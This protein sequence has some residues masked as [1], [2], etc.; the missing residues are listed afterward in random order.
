MFRTMLMLVLAAAAGY[1]GWIAYGLYNEPKQQLADKQAELEKVS[2]DLTARR[3]EIVELTTHLE[4]K[5]REIDR[6]EVA[7]QLLK[8]RH[9][10]ARLKVLDQQEVEVPA[11]EAGAAPTKK[12][13]TK[14]E[15]VE[16]N[17]E[18]QP[19]GKPREFEIDGD[20]VFIDYLRV[21]FDDKYVE[22]SDLD[23][24][25]AICLFQRV[26]GE[27]QQPIDGFQLDD[28]GARPTAYARGS[29]MSDFERKIWS[30]FWTIANDPQQAAEMGIHAAH[31]VASAMRVKPGKTYEVD[32]RSTGDM[33]IRPVDEP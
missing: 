13:I 2:A 24:S 28:V 26:F 12:L 16:V 25:T 17:E 32:L 15:F 19:I 11:A 3:Q 10:L 22:Q 21:T 8:V 4:E 29:E 27:H 7:M 20:L 1:G 5:S 30:D 9:R 31:E 14:I 6:L 23:R 18:G 33:T